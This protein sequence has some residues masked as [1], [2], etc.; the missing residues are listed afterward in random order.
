MSTGALKCVSADGESLLKGSYRIIF[1]FP[2]A[3][4]SY[5]NRSSTLCWVLYSL[6]LRFRQYSV[7]LS[8]LHRARA[9]VG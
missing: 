3:V 7:L 4:Y 5:G 8:V 2:R 9:G 6:Q 1:K